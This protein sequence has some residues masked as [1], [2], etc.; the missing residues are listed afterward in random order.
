MRST[1]GRSEPIGDRPRSSGRLRRYEI[2]TKLADVSMPELDGFELA[3][4]LRKHPRYEKTAI[5]FVST[6]LDVDR[7]RV[8]TGTTTPVP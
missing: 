5:I 8:T 4:M 6:L 7:I 2:A 1:E 3:K